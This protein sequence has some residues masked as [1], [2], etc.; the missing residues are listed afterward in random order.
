[1]IK[2]YTSLSDLV[3]DRATSYVKV[4]VAKEAKAHVQILP[5]SFFQTL[6][7]LLVSYLILK[8]RPLGNWHTV[9]EEETS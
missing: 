5:R 6:L 8:E 1:M 9:Q 4:C 2:I 7:F 3:A